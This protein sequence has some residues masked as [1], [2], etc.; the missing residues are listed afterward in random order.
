MIADGWKLGEKSLVPILEDFQKSG[1]ID[2]FHKFESMVDKS[3]EYLSLQSIDL[4]DLLP[5]VAPFESPYSSHSE[6]I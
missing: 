6:Y 1:I 2:D 5:Y 4:D 3:E